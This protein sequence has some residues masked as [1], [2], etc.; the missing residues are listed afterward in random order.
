MAHTGNTFCAFKYIYRFSFFFFK[1]FIQIGFFRP[2]NTDTA[3]L[4]TN[5]NIQHISSKEMITVGTS[6]TDIFVTENRLFFIFFLISMKYFTTR[7]ISPHFHCHHLTLYKES[8]SEN[9]SIILYSS[10]LSSNRRKLF[11]AVYC[12][13]VC[14]ET[15]PLSCTRFPRAWLGEG[16][17]WMRSM[18]RCDD[19]TPRVSAR[20]CGHF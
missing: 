15:R 1:D 11:S 9:V 8:L 10:S 4:K 20:A 3:Q 2:W 13:D 5:K 12:S 19:V 18:W 16:F 7:G 6:L 14:W 17:D